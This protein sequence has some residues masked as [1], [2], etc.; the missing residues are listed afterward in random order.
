MLR[1]FRDVKSFAKSIVHFDVTTGVTVHVFDDIE[2]PSINAIAGK[3][4]K[5]CLPAHQVESL[6]QVDKDSIDFLLGLSVLL[7]DS[8]EGKDVI[9]ALATFLKTCLIRWIREVSVS[10]GNE[11]VQQH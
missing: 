8:Q 4:E 2:E 11:P 7:H 6:P 9:V 3:F 1:A 5:K 10:M